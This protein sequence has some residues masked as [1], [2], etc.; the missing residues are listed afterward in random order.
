MQAKGYEAFDSR[1]KLF[2]DV[3]EAVKDDKLNIIGVYGMGG[4]GN[5]TLVKQV[6][7]QVMEDN[8][9]DK[10]V[11][12]EVTQDPNSQKI[13]DKLASDLGMKFSLNDSIHHKNLP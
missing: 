12:A 4:M 1:M 8:S 2:Q 11:M 6:A 13:Q 10:A 7:K 3:L 5:T 9:F